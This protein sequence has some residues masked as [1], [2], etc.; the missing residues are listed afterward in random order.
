MES[1]ERQK[2]LLR[3]Q[4]KSLSAEGVEISMKPL[5]EEL[6]GQSGLWGLYKPLQDEPVLKDLPSNEDVAWPYIVDLALSEMA[7][8]KSDDFKTSDLGFK[9]PVLSTAVPQKNISVILIPGQAFDFKG[10]RLGRG[11]GFYD[12]YLKD[13]NGVT[14]GVCSRQ[15][16]LSEPVPVDQKFDVAVQYVLTEQFLYKVNPKERA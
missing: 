12:R 5:M 8:S 1:L 7:F 15:R 2:S 9:E 13:F 6:K 10:N 3:A 14:V 16:F 4:V 11:K